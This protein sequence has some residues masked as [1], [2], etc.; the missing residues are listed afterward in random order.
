MLCVGDVRSHCF[1]CTKKIKVKEQVGGRGG[2]CYHI[3]TMECTVLQVVPLHRVS[4]GED[5]SQP[6]QLWWAALRCGR[7][8][9]GGG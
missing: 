4:P 8:R 5:F 3:N 6:G 2:K 9:C 7:L 1:K